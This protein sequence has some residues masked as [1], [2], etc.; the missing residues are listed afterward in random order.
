M[1]EEGEGA[2]EVEEVDA[3]VVLPI[4]SARTTPVE[5]E[6]TVPV[7]E[8][9]SPRTGRGFRV[10]LLAAGDRDEAESMAREARARLRAPVY[11]VF[12]APFY[13]VRAGDH[14]DRA[15][16]LLLRDL[17]RRNGYDGAWVVTTEI[18]LEP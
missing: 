11:V 7:Q 15:D 14:V 12:E 1:G 16:A 6:V 17:A 2:V 10:Q 8:Q 4:P 9:A 13:K 5:P 3:P 18:R